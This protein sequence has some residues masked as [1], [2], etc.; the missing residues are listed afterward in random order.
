[1]V[2]VAVVVSGW[3]V[4]LTFGPLPPRQK[5][6]VAMPGARSASY[7]VP[8]QPNREGALPSRWA[9]KFAWLEWAPAPNEHQRLPK[10][11]LLPPRRLYRS[12]DAKKMLQERFKVDDTEFELRSDDTVRGVWCWMVVIVVGG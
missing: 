7:P 4:G 10:K 12:A 11:P 5:N 9:L 8:A 3:V 1:M 2:S 6:K